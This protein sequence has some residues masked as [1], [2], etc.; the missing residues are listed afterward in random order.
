MLQSRE[1]KIFPTAITA[2]EAI[3]AYMEKLISSNFGRFDIALSGG[4]SPKNL[5][6]VLAG[7]FAG[8]I[9]WDNVHF[10]WSDERC[11]PPED[12]ESNYKMAKE[13][14][15]EPL[16]KIASD[17]IHR[18]KGEILPEDS[19]KEYSDKI[20]TNLKIREGI[21]VF[22]LILLGMG[23]DGHTASLF[24]DQLNLLK[25]DKCCEVSTFPSTGQKR[26]TFTAKLINNAENVI[27]F[28]PGISK[29]QRVKEIVNGDKQSLKL[30]ANY[31]RPQ[32]GNL[33]FFLDESSA[34]L[35]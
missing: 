16:K 5:F 24:P 34:G 4:N 22:N 2:A 8:K 9:F 6:D 18:I 1:I 17:H 25:S 28:V 23:P 33:L 13:H 11:V 29:Q 31:I 7:K 3:A 30:P 35:L 21:P 20:M 15:L 27:F 12:D 14:L 32:N 10:W 19:S 26:V